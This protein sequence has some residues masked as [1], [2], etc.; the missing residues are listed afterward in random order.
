MMISSAA[1]P[2]AIIKKVGDTMTLTWP[3]V[4]Q[5]TFGNP[6]VPN[7]YNVW[8]S[9]VSADGSVIQYYSQVKGNVLTFAEKAIAPGIYCYQVL[10]G[11]TGDGE[12]SNVVCFNVAKPTG[13]AAAPVVSG[14]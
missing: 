7:Y 8:K 12:L 5:D 11:V 1:F 9:T 6:I 4:T 13:P 3:A 10:A 2:A 14:S